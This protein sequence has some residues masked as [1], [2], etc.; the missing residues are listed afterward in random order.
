MIKCS[1]KPESQYQK[2]KSCNS[3]FYWRPSSS[4]HEISEK[5]ETI[6]KNRFSSLRG[7]KTFTN[8]KILNKFSAFPKKNLNRIQSSLTTTTKKVDELGTGGKK[9]QQTRWLLD[10]LTA[11]DLTV[12]KMTLDELTNRRIISNEFLTTFLSP[13]VRPNVFQ[14]A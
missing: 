11:D 10:E 9:L 5:F 3:K 1:N 13:L 8:K 14:K 12:D 2:C 6:F 4:F 7:K